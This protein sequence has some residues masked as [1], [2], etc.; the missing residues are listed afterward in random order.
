LEIAVNQGNIVTL[1]N[2]STASEIRIKFNNG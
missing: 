1:E 2:L